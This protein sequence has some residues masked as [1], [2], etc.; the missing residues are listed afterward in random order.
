MPTVKIKPPEPL[1]ARGLSEQRFE[2]WKM[3]LR[4][5]L[6]SD[7]MFT[8]F[9]PTGRYSNWE[10]EE[11]NPDRIPALAQP[12]PELQE[13]ATPEQIQDLLQQRRNQLLIFI[14]QVAK[15]VSVNHY[16]TVVRHCTSLQWVFDKVR[17]D[18]DITQRGIHFMNLRKI[19]YDPA[20]MTPTGFYQAYRAHLI[21]HTARAGDRIA[22][23]NRN[24]VQAETLGPSYED[25]ILYVVIN[26]ID[27]RLLKY[28]HKH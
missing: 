5:W 25:F 2:M 8:R 26:E 6:S 13:D 3:E 4:A 27:S 14:S 17:E 7:P 10:S 28:V 18:Y 24:Q 19:K 20:T 22:W 21:N 12:D 15:C 1:P 16:T 23:A 9:L 11:E